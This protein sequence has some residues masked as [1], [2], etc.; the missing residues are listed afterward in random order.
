MRERVL[1]IVTLIA[2]FVMEERDTLSEN[3][4]VEELLSVGFEADEI[5]AA[6]SWMETLS[7]QQGTAPAPLLA[8]STH[9]IFTPEECRTLSSEARGFLIRLR[10][11]GILNDE[12]QE[13]IIER[14]M[15]S[16]EDAVCLKEMKTLTALIL[17]ARSHDEWRREADRLLEDDWS[18]MYH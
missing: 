1:A 10:M 18:Q 16:S 14:A 5:D 8:L 17:F 2:Q 11:M 13:E 12:L 6:F 4:I 9:R 15:Q 7:L 3:E